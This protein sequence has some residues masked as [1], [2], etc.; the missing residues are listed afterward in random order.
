MPSTRP[1]PIPFPGTGATWRWVAAFRILLLLVAA[2]ALAFGTAGSHRAAGAA[3]RQVLYTCPMHPEVRETSPGQCP[4]CHMA[5]EPAHRSPAA[6][7]AADPDALRNLQAH[8]YIV[9]V[10]R[11]RSLLFNARELRGPARVEDDGTVTAVFYDDQIRA[12]AEGDGGV[13]APTGDPAAA[14]AVRRT[15]DPLS[16]WDG[17]TSSIRFR[18]DGPIAAGRAGWLEL[19]RRP[20]DVLTVPTSAVLQSAEG[21]YVLMPAG[22]RRF[23]R[24][25]IEI[26]ETFLGLDYAVVLS[27]LRVQDRVVA[28]SSFFLDAERRL[29]APPTRSDGGAP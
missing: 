7:A 26:G 15:G 9:D 13:F 21:P 14:V 2:G 27:G 18:A 6:A 12:I 3:A 10:V 22:P 17:S 4:I 20:R 29:D 8:G 28:R 16:R 24:R 11:R 19:P 1:T 23:E 25:R 5:L